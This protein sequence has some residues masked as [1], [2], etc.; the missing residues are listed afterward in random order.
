V[1]LTRSPLS[2]GRSPDCVRLACVR[3]AA[4]VDS[5]PGSNSH[6][7]FAVAL[8]FARFRGLAQGKQLIN[9]S[10][11]DLALLA[12][13]VLCPT[14]TSVLAEFLRRRVR[15]YIYGTACAVPS[16]SDSADTRRASNVALA[17]AVRNPA[18]RREDVLPDNPAKRRQGVLPDKV[19][20]RTI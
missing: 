4:S 7:K 2:Q 3:H 13:F 19:L 12:L 20:A 10:A 11:D 14:P 8:R 9:A 18:K 5:E 17:S 6:V 16:M 15:F 1:L